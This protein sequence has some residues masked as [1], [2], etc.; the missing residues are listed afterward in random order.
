[1]EDFDKLDFKTWTLPHAFYANMGGIMLEAP[2]YQGFSL[3]ASQL[4]FLVE[5]QV[6]GFFRRKPLRGPKK[7]FEIGTK[8]IVSLASLPSFEPD[9]LFCGFWAVSLDVLPLIVLTSP[10]WLS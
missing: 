9:G 6:R 10:P 8:I 2:D 4:C 5:K 7:T 3:N 1:M